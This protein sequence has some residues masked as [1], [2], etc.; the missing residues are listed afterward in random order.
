MQGT[1]C[2]SCGVLGRN[3]RPLKRSIYRA[4]FMAL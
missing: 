2:P 3:H 1:V 4:S